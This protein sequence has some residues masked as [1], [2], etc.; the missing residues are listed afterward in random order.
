MRHIDR[1]MRHLFPKYFCIFVA[2]LREWSHVRL[3]LGIPVH[4]ADKPL[5]IL[6]V[7]F[8]LT[9]QWAWWRSLSHHRGKHPTPLMNSQT[10]IQDKIFTSIIK[11]KTCMKKKQL[12]KPKWLVTMLLVMAILMPSGGG[13]GTDNEAACQRWR[14]S[15]QTLWDILCCR[16]GVVPRLCE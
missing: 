10:E 15:R 3:L 13:M 1:G 14:L 11:N 8:V 5:I 6:W 9:I 12:H 4:H 16:T 2:W 7:F